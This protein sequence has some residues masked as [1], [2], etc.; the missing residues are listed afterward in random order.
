MDAQ[1]RVAIPGNDAWAPLIDVTG[2]SIDDLAGSAEAILRR[3]TCRL[4]ERLDD[5]TGRTSALGP[6]AFPDWAAAAGW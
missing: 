2:L 6:C 5:S 3:S 1:S 4:M